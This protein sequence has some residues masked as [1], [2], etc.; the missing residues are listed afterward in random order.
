MKI[1]PEDMDDVRAALA[2]FEDPFGSGPAN[3]QRDIALALILV[4]IYD[5]GYEA[6][7]NDHPWDR[8]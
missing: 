6:A 2:R 7:I 5:R 8:A 1:T 4:R 3:E